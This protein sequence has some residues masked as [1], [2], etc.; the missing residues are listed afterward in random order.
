MSTT[1]KADVCITV[2]SIASFPAYITHSTYAIIRDG[3]PTSRIVRGNQSGPIDGSSS[4]FSNIFQQ[5]PNRR[6][7]GTDKSVTPG[8]TDTRSGALHLRTRFRPLRQDSRFFFV[9]IAASF[10]GKNPL[11]LLALLWM[12]ATPQTRTFCSPGCI[13]KADRACVPADWTR[14]DGVG[15]RSPTPATGWFGSGFFW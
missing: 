9:P 12:T 6:N 14:S 10:G 4:R 5:V 15:G 2:R 1:T 7:K 11:S 13:W 3:R 8:R